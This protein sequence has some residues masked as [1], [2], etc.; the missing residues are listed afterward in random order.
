MGL[1]TVTA[2]S[3]VLVIR[4]LDT[5]S[6]AELMDLVVVFTGCGMGLVTVTA[7]TEVL[8][9]RVVEFGLLADLTGLL[10]D[11]VL[12]LLGRGPK[13]PLGLTGLAVR[14]AG[15]LEVL[16]E[17]TTDLVAGLLTEI[18]T[19]FFVVLLTEVKVGLFAELFVE[20]KAGLFAELFVEVKEGL[21]AELLG[22][23]AFVLVF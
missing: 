1:V 6:L 16:L 14:L 11:R 23:G 20:V 9:T 18:E 19:G 2:V 15:L 7:T 10:A 21:F 4:V 5:G 3:E 13:V 17:L 22:F 8:V 12:L